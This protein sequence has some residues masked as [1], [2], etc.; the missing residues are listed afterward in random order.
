MTAALAQIWRHPVKS[1]GSEPL[2]RVSLQAGQSMPWDRTWAIAHEAAKTAGNSWGRSANFSRGAKAPGLMGISCT[3]EE[4]T[5]VVTFRHP[6]LNTV[7]LHPER[8]AAALLDWSRP[9]LPDDRAQSARVIRLDGRGMTDTPYPSVSLMN[10]ST[11]RQVADRLDMPDLDIRRWRGNFWIDG[12]PAWQELDWIGRKLRLGAALLQVEEPVV[13]C[14]ATAANPRTGERDADTLGALQQGWG[15]RHF[16]VYAR[17]IA[18]GDVLCGDEL[19]LI[20]E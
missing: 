20:A 12:L 8:D 18:A 4:E 1:H 11:H 7:S 14:L 2:S 6:D 5:E 16:G 15:H 9:L 17:V 19:T 10:L 13:R 3:L